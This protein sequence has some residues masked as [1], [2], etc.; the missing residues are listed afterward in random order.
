MKKIFAPLFSMLTSVVLLLVFAIA[1]AYA[2]FIENDYGTETA[3]ILIYN[4]NWFNL[5][6]AFGAVNLIGGLFYHRAFKLKRWSMVLFH[7]A[8]VLMVIGAGITRFYSYEGMMHI[9]EGETSNLL[10]S[11]QTFIQLEVAAGGETD[12]ENWA[13]RYSPYTHNYFNKHVSLLGKEIELNNLFFVPN[14]VQSVVADELGSP[15]MS[16]IVLDKSVRKDIVLELHEVHQFD[17]FKVSFEGAK[18]SETIWLGRTGERLT[19]TPP[20]TMFIVTLEGLEGDTLFPGTEYTLSNKNM[21]KLGDNLFVLQTYFHKGRKSLATVQ[22]SNRASFPDALQLTVTVDEQQK[23]VVCY[24]NKGLVSDPV[25][26]RLGELDLKLSYGSK[27]IELPFSLRLNEF[28]LERYPGSMS[29]SSFASEVT[30]IDPE[31]RLELP[32]RIYMNNILD[33]GGYRFFQSS[34]DQ[35]EK[36]TI[37]SVSHDRVG[38]A[39]TYTGY[40]LMT[41]GLLFTFFN[42]RS[43]FRFLLRA[44]SRLKQLKNKSVIGLLLSVLLFLPLFSEANNWK[45]QKI[46]GKHIRAFDELLVQDR[47]GRIEP[48]NTLSSKLLRK[49]IRKNNLR[50]MSASEVFLGMN[51]FPE[52]WKNEKLIRISNTELARQMGISGNLASFNQLVD[53]NQGSYRLRSLVDEAYHKKPIERN[54]FDKEVIAVDERVNICYQIFNGD[55]LRIFPDSTDSNRTWYTEKTYF[56][57]RSAMGSAVDR[58]LLTNYLQT[59]QQAVGTNDYQAANYSLQVLKDFQHAHGADLI[60]S[61]TKVKLE[62]LYNRYDIFGFFSKLCGLL[63]SI[64][65]VMHLIEIFNSRASL[66]KFLLPGTILLFAVFLIYTAGLAV[67]WYISGHAPWSNAYETLLFIGWATLLSGFVFLRKS[68]ITLAVTSIL[69]SLILMVAGMSWMNPE[70]TNLVP[71]LKSYWLIVHVAVITASYGFLGIG[72]LLGL[73]NMVIMMLRTPKNLR[74]T[75]ITISEVSIII[76]LALL[77]G[78]TLLIVGCFIGAVWANESWGR[79]WGWDPKETW[80]LVTILVYSTILHLRKVPGLYNYFILSALALIGFSSV[81]MTFFGVNYYLSGMHSYA[82]GD[83][84]PV[85]SSVYIAV[86]VVMAIVVLA[87]ISERKHGSAEKT[88]RLETEE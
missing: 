44:S 28:Q 87:A 8:F 21:Y 25:A 43:R 19:L 60:L 18:D 70:I 50:G 51:A 58:L 75:S 31:A 79:Y 66:R 62:I 68:Q 53:L 84:P 74:N 23:D 12:Q 15:V 45:D 17:E 77:V 49:L 72:A 88:V 46:D 86:I 83:A 85:P 3:R 64:L 40:L 47:Q 73:L 10:V 7:L 61:K 63:G 69:T 67:R 42:K 59:L 76:E 22:S 36:G 29:P 2:T 55:F 34:Y 38:T 6:L 41:I 5:L 71:V 56:S 26:F 16:F 14:G 1:I 37:L 24:G 78:L 81:L 39:T 52:S 54:K 9:R 4:A 48:V 82:Q 32:Y 13:V 20:D 65:L 11:D 33:Y 35:D 57:N 27:A 80:T 30:L